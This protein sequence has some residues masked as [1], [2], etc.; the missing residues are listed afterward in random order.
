MPNESSS[1]NQKTM[2]DTN[3]NQEDAL[4]TQE[5]LNLN[6]GMGST[7]GPGSSGSFF[8]HTATG[9]TGGV[10]WPSELTSALDQFCNDEIVDMDAFSFQEALRELHG[11]TGGAGGDG[12]FKDKNLSKDE[13]GKR[14]KK[15]IHLYQD[16][17]NKM[18][19]QDEI[20]HELQVRHERMK[21][22][23]G[24][25]NTAVAIQA[26]MIGIALKRLKIVYIID[27]GDNW[28]TYANR[29]FFHLKKRSREK[30]MSVASIPNVEK[31]FHLGVERLNEFGTYLKNLKDDER[32]QLGPDPITAL[33]Q[34]YKIDMDA[35]IDEHRLYIDA[36]VKVIK[37]EA[38]GVFISVELM[39]KFLVKG[40]NLTG[41]DRKH[42]ISISKGEEKD[43][44]KEDKGS[45][46]E[47]LRELIA[48]NGDRTPLLPQADEESFSDETNASKIPNID[49]TMVTLRE[50]IKSVLESKIDSGK[51][52]VVTIDYLMADLQALK[53]KLAKA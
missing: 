25:A 40:L 35:D 41:E 11:A 1:Q 53:K 43:A 37:L 4:K 2:H 23:I 14:L 51:I 26:Y 39:K 20:L 15:M 48:N 46:A 5:D 16:K 28:I 50:S 12:V 17:L 18:E 34:R 32:E 19:T 9:G 33:C 29:V 27:G 38:A 10:G 22:V 3:N 47:Y 6:T 52:D 21:F 44:Q 8:P 45:A 13:E 30:Y 7:G 42:M 24:K 49:S 36:V 31:H